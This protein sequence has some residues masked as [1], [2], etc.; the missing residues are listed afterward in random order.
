MVNDS[1][2]AKLGPRRLPLYIGIVVVLL[3]LLANLVINS[4]WNWTTEYEGMF[5]TGVQD[6]ASITMQQGSVK[7]VGKRN[8]RSGFD[9]KIRIERSGE[10]IFEG[11]VT[12]KA[13]DDAPSEYAVLFRSE[14]NDL[15]SEVIATFTAQNLLWEPI[16]LTLYSDAIVKAGETRYV[17]F[18]APAE[19][20]EQVVVLLGL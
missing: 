11:E 16:V 14:S 5:V 20:K 7:L 9:G 13:V 8:I 1:T 3:F 15:S 17:Y 4:W 18:C 10:L 2:S 12:I 19:N 6:A